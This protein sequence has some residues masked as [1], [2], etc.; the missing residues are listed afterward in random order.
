MIRRGVG[1]DKAWDE[2]GEVSDDC[3]C[4]IEH[5][6][7]GRTKLGDGNGEVVEEE[8]GQLSYWRRVVCVLLDQ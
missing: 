3:L 8:E 4:N 5:W 6:N 1:M 7:N 2:S